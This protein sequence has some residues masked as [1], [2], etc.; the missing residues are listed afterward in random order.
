MLIRFNFS[1]FKSFYDS[2]TF[3]MM[4]GHR[5]S[6]KPHHVNENK[7]GNFQTLRGAI[8]YGHN[9]SGKSNFIAALDFMKKFILK[10]KSPYVKDN[11]FKLNPEAKEKPY[12]FDVEFKIDDKAYAYGFEYLYTDDIVQKEWLYEIKNLTNGNTKQDKLFTRET[13]NEGKLE[14]E[15]NSKIHNKFKEIAEEVVKKEG[16]VFSFIQEIEG[17]PLALPF[18][19]FKEHLL[20]LTPNVSA[21]EDLL[22]DGL[23]K[24][25]VFLEFLSDLLK[26]ANTGI[27]KI[28]LQEVDKRVEEIIPK[29]ILRDLEIK[30]KEKPKNKVYLRINK[31]RPYIIKYKQDSFIVEQLV[32]FHKNINNEGVP[33]KLSEES[34]GTRRLIDI[35]PAF[36][37][38]REE[39]SVLIIDELERHLHPLVTKTFWQS[40]IE[41]ED[42]KNHQLIL[43]THEDHLLECRSLYRNDEIWFVDKDEKGKSRIFSLLNFKIRDDKTINK[44]YMIGR[45]GAIGSLRSLLNG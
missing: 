2:N 22:E 30:L 34:S 45:Y 16:L 4:K 23:I 35:A 42:R 36:Y 13:N 44:D 12:H 1:N 24:E 7:A 29:E 3:S 38:T 17:N 5:M 20:I 6:K 28:D 33:F 19:W 14:I 40:H 18:K 26:N 27:D 32:A 8:I 10:G 25:E 11:S 43:A 15:F 31:G 37:N 21:G 9:A 41:N 39:Q